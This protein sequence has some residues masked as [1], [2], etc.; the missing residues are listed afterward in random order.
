MAYC[1]P[2][3]HTKVAKYVNVTATEEALT[4]AIATQ[5]VSVAV[6]AGGVNW[7]FYSSGVMDESCEDEVDHGVLA[8]GY[9]HYDPRNEPEFV[10]GTDSTQSAMDYYLV[11]N[12]WGSWWGIDGCKF[13]ML[14]ALSFLT[15]LISI[16][17][18]DI[19]LGRNI[20][21]VNGSSCILALASRPILKAED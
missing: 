6:T 3:K 1:E 4:A 20:G 15:E 9:G 17:A 19:R 12:S 7:Q 21:H 14:C 2:L 10:V 5:P 18:S 8:V 13:W 16:I 11:K